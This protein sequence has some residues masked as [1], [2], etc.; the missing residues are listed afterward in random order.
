MRVITGVDGRVLCLRE[1]MPPNGVGRNTEKRDPGRFESNLRTERETR[2]ISKVRST[3]WN[4]QGT[5]SCVQGTQHIHVLLC[6]WLVT[7]LQSSVTELI[8]RWLQERKL[9]SLRVISGVQQQCLGGASMFIK[10]GCVTTHCLLR[11]WKEGMEKRRHLHAAQL[12]LLHEHRP[13]ADVNQVQV[14][15]LQYSNPVHVGG[16]TGA[17][18]I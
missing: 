12:H 3:P 17:A 5:P 14:S 15:F 2:T 18:P 10:G 1:C 16:S 9:L 8:S 11:K 7:L 13:S 6:R 4:R